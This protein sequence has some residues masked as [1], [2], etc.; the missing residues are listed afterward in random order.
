MAVDVPV[1]QWRPTSGLTEMGNDGETNIT[2]LGDV[3][4]TTLSGVD[5]VTLE[6][7]V[8]MIPPTEWVEDDSV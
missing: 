6:G 3:Q 7:T 8:T 2:T 1:T 4:I 5:L